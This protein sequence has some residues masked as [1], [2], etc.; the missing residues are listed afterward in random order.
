MEREPQCEKARRGWSTPRFLLA[1]CLSLIAIL[2]PGCG[3]KP[4]PVLERCPPERARP[5]DSLYDAVAGAEVEGAA[6]RVVAD[7]TAEVV[8]TLLALDFEDG[9]LEGLTPLKVEGRRKGKG[10]DRAGSGGKKTKQ[11]TRVVREEGGHALHL[12]GGV[13]GPE[14]LIS[15]A[16][17]I[18]PGTTYTVTY[19]VRARDLATREGPNYRFGTV[20][21]RF[22][23]VP[24]HYHDATRHLRTGSN[25]LRCRQR[26]AQPAVGPNVSGTTDWETHS[27]S[28]TAPPKA[29]RV[30]LFLDHTRREPERGIPGG[31][32]GDVWFDDVMLTA[33]GRPINTKYANP[34]DLNGAPSPLQL[35]VEL[36]AEDHGAETR[37]AL[38]A[39]APSV[40]RFRRE[41]P[42]SATLSLA[43]GVAP[44]G[45]V[46]GRGG[47]RFTVT[48]VD[49]QGD[50]H[51]VL[52][53][54]H[55]PGETSE[56]RFWR[57]HQVD[58]EDFA[59]QQVSIELAT[60][61][62]NPA[63]R[64]DYPGAAAVWGDPVLFSRDGRGRLIVLV[65][66]D[67]VSVSHVSA[68]GYDRPTTPRLEGIATQGVLFEYAYSAAP[69]TLPSFASFFTGIDPARHGAGERAWREVIWRRPLGEQYVTLAER[70]RAAGFQTVAF[71]NNPYLT[72]AFGLGQ[73]FTTYRDYGVG[74]R[75]GSG[76]VGVDH[77]IEWLDTH[78]GYDRFLVVHLMDCHGPYRPPR[79]Y[80]QKFVSGKYE[81]RFEKGMTGK[82]YLDLAQADVPARDELEKQQVRD[83]YDGA[84]LY[85]DAMMG[86]LYDHVMTEGGT[87]DV[88]FVVT[89]D[90]GE[91][92]WEHGGYEHGHQTYQELIRVPL[93]MVGPAAF[94]GGRRLRLPVRLPDLVPTLLDLMG[95]SGLQ[96]IDGRSLVPMLQ[97][98]PAGWGEDRE[99]FAENE[100]YGSAQAALVQG[101]YKYLYA[102]KN[103]S[104]KERRALPKYRHEL[105]DL[106]ADPGETR[107]LVRI[108]PTKLAAM[109]RKMDRHLRPMLAGHYVLVL[110]G[111]GKPRRFQ[112]SLTLPDHQ[113]W[114]GYYEDIVA[115]MP[116][117]TEGTFRVTNRRGRIAFD[118]TSPR[119]VLA[120]RPD[121]PAPEGK[122]AITL[123]VDVDG[124]PWRAGVQTPRGETVG[125][126]ALSVTCDDGLL[127]APP[128]ALPDSIAGEVTI[129]LARLPRRTLDARQNKALSEDT[130]ARL[131]ALGYLK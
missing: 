117:G 5:V 105:Y 101:R 44:E 119:A 34:D 126:G 46:R 12:G 29:N 42:P 28:F 62:E 113:R 4:A 32:R 98:K 63:Y 26:T 23:A 41:I 66:I 130:A 108:E 49:A 11:V 75:T 112:G 71:M 9:T 22:Y 86:R 39:P 109:H 37:Y 57:P 120:F 100:L 128:D 1:A 8:N 83:L 6:A 25:R 72:T 82:D 65:V 121:H 38:Y 103:S 36:P 21:A 118:V 19:R 94:D 131:R 97:G 20:E 102:M 48:V 110:D 70:L 54:T 59:G 33:R 89:S 91:E 17:P 7:P 35:R 80:A 64:D 58:L 116:D 115:P 124:Q 87:Q 99:L 107:S 30:M 96:E 81:G 90:H 78:R 69:W 27:F 18:V 56:E 31:S 67:A 73:G 43:T 50:R 3:E 68:Y 15:E 122:G 76:K 55:R 52:E 74:T 114:F 14:S 95:V 2:A 60:A 10:N 104:P 123:A 47:V 24:D 93:V 129:F 53:T 92:L 79:A 77:A 84:I 16:I 85:A 111:G 127:V 61:A 125:E 40:L 13:M 45:W 88:T 51:V 106:K